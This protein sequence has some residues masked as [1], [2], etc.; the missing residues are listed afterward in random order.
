VSESEARALASEVQRIRLAT[1]AYSDPAP[2][3]GRHLGFILEDNAVPFGAD[4]EHKQVDLYGYTS[5]LVAAI[6]QRAKQIETL[7][8]EVQLLREAQAKRPVAPCRDGR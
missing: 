2:A 8:R 3:G 7:E 1:S 5:T 6:R 4:A